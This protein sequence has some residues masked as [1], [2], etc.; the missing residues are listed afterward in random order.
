MPAILI[1][2]QGRYRTVNRSKETRSKCD[3][4]QEQS[5]VPGEPLIH[6]A[7]KTRM[8]EFLIATKWKCFRTNR[9]VKVRWNWSATGTLVRLA[10]SRL[11]SPCLALSRHVYDSRNTRICRSA[12]T[13]IFRRWNARRVIQ[14]KRVIAL[15]AKPLVSGAAFTFSRALTDEEEALPCK[16]SARPPSTSLTDGI[17]RKFFVRSSVILWTFKRPVSPAFHETDAICWIFNE[18]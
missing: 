5:Y 13:A 2:I 7:P 14:A 4:D 15:S 16:C 1:K 9:W 6:R 11:V 8:S 18:P 17:A 12:L 3:I 10:S